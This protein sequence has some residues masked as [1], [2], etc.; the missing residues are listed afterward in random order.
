MKTVIEKVTLLLLLAVVVFAALAHGVV[1]SW[2]V[3]VVE[4][5]GVVLLL[6]WAAK[7]T[8]E[9]RLRLR[10]PAL[11]LPIVALLALALL[12]GLAFRGGDGQLRSLSMDVEAT[13]RATLLFFFLLVCLFVA[14]EL[15][16]TRE[17][18]RGLMNFL[19]GYGLV[20]AMFAL[21]QHF[22]WNGKFYWFKPNRNGMSPFGPF[23][24]H[25]HFAGYMEMLAPLALAAACGRGLR[26]EARLFYGFA[27]AMMMTASVASLSR[28]G[29]ISL[30]ASLLFFAACHLLWRWQ[31][32]R[33]AA[34]FY[35]DA[36]GRQ[37]A[38]RL[39]SRLGVTLKGAALVVALVMMILVSL[40]WIG[41]DRLAGRLNVAAG[42]NP[43]QRE[44]FYD[45]RGW[46]WRDAWAMIARQ[47]LLGVGFGAFETAHPLYST[48]DGALVVAQA[49]NDYLQILADT[50]IVGG[51]LALWFVALF[52]RELGRALRLRDPL[53]VAVSIGSGT[54][55]FAILAHSIFDFNL[56]L[57][58]NVL[59]FFL[60]VACLT[61]AVWLGRRQEQND[62]RADQQMRLAAVK[63]RKSLTAQVS[64]S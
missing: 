58:S 54:G 20:M 13:R 37:A 29:M 63:D 23:V 3:A 27:A 32:Q 22:T 48:S 47:P 4:V 25:N 12:H 1:D 62:G 44:T 51:V 24:S 21:I 59:L 45:S 19:V 39:A 55:I 42:T 30:A 16:S 31:P 17:R 43:E 34:A 26:L 6:L 18:L 52:F 40:V 56:Q 11:V 46:I 50:G 53:L 14:L 33:A 10:L 41:P 60:L 35:E 15:F 5:A 64:K 9:S 61:Q 28:G 2:S 8:L 57:P 36:G 49:H 38:N 7:L